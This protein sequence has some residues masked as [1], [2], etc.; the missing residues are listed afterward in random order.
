GTPVV[1]PS[2]FRQN[3]LEVT[4][5]LTAGFGGH[6]LTLGAHAGLLRSDDNQLTFGAG[7]WNFRNLD[8]LAAGHAFHY[9]RALTGP[10]GTSGVTFHTRQIGLY[11]QDRWSPTHALTLTAGLRID[12]TFLPDAVATN[13][14]LKA[15]LGIDTGMLP[16][17]ALLWSP[18]LG[19]NYD[20]GGEGRTFIRGGI[21]LFGG[22][23]PYAWV[24]SAYRDDGADGARVVLQRRE[25]GSTNRGGPGRG[26]P[27]A[28]RDDQRGRVCD[29]HASGASI[30]FSGA[31]VRPERRPLLHAGG[32]VAQAVGRSC[33]GECVLRIHAGS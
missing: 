9:E 15:A 24:G 5:N 8:S 2:S 29:T 32:P 11:A 6:V 1:C 22:D 21:G 13:A 19:F 25:P 17:G 20:L 23:P 4:E 28:L 30:R 3:A 27:P 7:L 18:R 31:R 10:S 14:S 26:E 33:R 12:V 16:S